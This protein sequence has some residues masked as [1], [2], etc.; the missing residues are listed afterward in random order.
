MICIL[1]PPIVVAQC[2]RAVKPKLASPAH[3][4]GRE[5]GGGVVRM[6]RVF[7]C[8]WCNKLASDQLETLGSKQNET[9]V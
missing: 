5:G 2:Y 9:D 8:V 7:L 6:L 3:Q 1:P 4:M